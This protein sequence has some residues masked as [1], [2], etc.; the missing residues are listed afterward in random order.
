MFSAKYDLSGPIKYIQSTDKV[1]QRTSSHLATIVSR[2]LLPQDGRIPCPVDRNREFDFLFIFGQCGDNCKLNLFLKRKIG[3]TERPRL[4]NP[5]KALTMA[6]C[7]VQ[8]LARAL[9]V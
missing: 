4:L 6:I 3:V 2:A 7:S 8:Y 9:D 5:S 1:R